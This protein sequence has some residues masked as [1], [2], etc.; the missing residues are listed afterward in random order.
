[1]ADGVSGVRKLQTEGKCVIL[2]TVCLLF[3]VVVVVVV[4]R[5]TSHY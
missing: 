5:S 2:Y 4:Y 1:M 3:D